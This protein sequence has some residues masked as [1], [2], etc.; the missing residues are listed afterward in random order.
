MLDN[1]YTPYAIISSIYIL[2][3]LHYI[4]YITIFT[5]HYQVHYHYITL[6][7]HLSMLYCSSAVITN[8]HFNLQPTYQWY[9]HK[10]GF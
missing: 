6:S 7:S 8:L 4:I 2:L 10:P 3:Y 9:N 1:F 5:L